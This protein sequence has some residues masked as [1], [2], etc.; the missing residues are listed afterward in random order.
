MIFTIARN[1]LFDILAT[2]TPIAE[3]KSTLPVLSN[4]LLEVADGHI[5]ASATDLQ[6]GL[7]ITKECTIKEEGKL[8]VQPRRFLDFVREL[9]AED[10]DAVLT[11]SSR[12]RITCGKSIIELAG[13]DAGEFPSWANVEGIETY[14]V[15]SKL[16]LDML[17][18][19]VFASS[20]DESRFNL[21]GTLIEQNDDKIRMVATDGHRLAMCEA[22]P[23][24][25]LTSSVL[26]PKK[27]LNEL[28]R[29]LE[30]APE[31]VSIGFE[32][33]NMMIASQEI[34]MSLRL[35]DGEYP[36]YN[37]VLPPRGET[38]ITLNRGRLLQ[39]A[40]RVAVL[41]SERN[42]GI[43]LAV[44]P[45]RIDF[46]ASHP[47]LGSVEDVMDIDY[48]G[49]QFEAIV[50]VS[51]LIDALSALDS[52]EITIEYTKEGNPIVIRPKPEDSYF[53]MVMPM[54]K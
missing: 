2:T 6:V 32:E 26:V 16:L 34:F 14:E 54:R 47:E 49:P 9:P 11:E 22:E 21:N 10:V 38:P 40:R 23:G 30:N 42:K 37:R 18:K 7:K 28:R 43:T 29:I 27:S 33:K 20:N 24:L 13:I 12:L 5:T 4:I 51:Y 52:E 44:S 17:E 41:T 19:T 50:N 48:D 25:K 53:N 3:K 35:L 36:D 31:T 1:S 8:A 46:T 15:K 45:G 39:T